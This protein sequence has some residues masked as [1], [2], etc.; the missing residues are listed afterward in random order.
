MHELAG[1][2]P[3]VMF[4]RPR[5]VLFDVG[6]TLI[7]PSGAILIEELAAHSISVSVD[8]DTAARALIVSAEARHVPLPAHLDGTERVALAWGRLLGVDSAALPACVAALNRPDLYCELDPGAIGTLHSLKELGLAL[9]AVSNSA[10]TVRA[11]LAAFDLLDLFDVVIDSTV[12]GIEK[13]APGI[14]QQALVELGLTGSDCW[15]VG[16]GLVNDVL[17]ALGAGLAGGVLYDRFLCF[18]HLHGVARINALDDL[19]SAVSLCD[20]R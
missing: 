5:A 3:P 10:G 18:E 14:F 19:V 7:H 8:A 4:R 11:D 2:W 1:Y 12:V 17:A 9:G 13:P 15:F 20:Q 6:M 16:D